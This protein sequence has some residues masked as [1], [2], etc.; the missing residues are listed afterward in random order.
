MN[1]GEKL[2]RFCV[3]IL[4]TG[5][6]AAQ[7]FDKPLK[8][9]VVD[10]GAS[11]YYGAPYY[12]KRTAPHIELCCY[13]YD[14]FMIKEYDE[15]QKGAEW[16]A[17]TPTR[18]GTAA[19]C[20]KAH[21]PGE[22]VIQYPEWGGYFLGVKGKLVLFREADGMNGVIPFAVYDGTTLKKI[23]DDN[24]YDS[25]YR[26]T[27]KGTAPFDHLRL[28]QSADGQ[29]RLVYLRGE[30]ADCDLPMKGKPCWQKIRERFKLVQAQMPKCT[31]Y[32]SPEIRK[33]RPYASAILYPVEVTL[34]PKPVMKTIAGP[35][36]CWPV[37]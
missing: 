27:R 14:H 25:S 16:L 26:T 36:K 9:Q 21:G 6:A 34:F 33:Y 10:F 20:E 35:V 29:G 5:V 3:L 7:S 19:K 4:L 17:I 23:F 30:E 1:A 2:V 24:S 28:W 13:F 12:T 18:D 15:K 8:K 22:K 32:D 31:G 11:P 37:D